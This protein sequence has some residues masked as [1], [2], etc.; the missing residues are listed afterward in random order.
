MNENI[1]FKYKEHKY[2]KIHRY[3]HKSETINVIIFL[4]LNMPFYKYQSKKR[5]IF[6]LKKKRTKEWIDIL[7]SNLIVWFNYAYCLRLNLI[8]SRLTINKNKKII[9]YSWFTF[10]YFFS[11]LLVR[12]S[13][14]SFTFLLLLLQYSYCSCCYYCSFPNQ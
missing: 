3:M 8:L 4:F 2:W 14:Y 12:I 11:F 5:F 7:N 1:I 6:D 10:S 9:N 13:S